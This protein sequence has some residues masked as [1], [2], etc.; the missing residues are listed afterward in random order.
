MS[1][2]T[3]RVRIV[4][5]EEGKVAKI[6]DL[7]PLEHRLV[8][9]LDGQSAGELYCSR[10]SLEALAVGHLAVKGKLAAKGPPG[11]S[12]EEG[13]HSTMA[14]VTTPSEAA[15]P[16]PLEDAA[17]PPGMGEPIS[18]QTII[19]NMDSLAESSEIFG[20]TGAAHCSGY[21]LGD[22]SLLLF[23]DIARHNTIDRIIGSSILRTM[24]LSR[25]MI[26]TTGRV[27][28]EIA[29]RCVQA[30]VTALVSRGA[31]TGRAIEISRVGGLTLVGFAR[32]HRFNCYSHPDR[33]LFAK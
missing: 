31:P 15:T 30:G 16:D 14:R 20:A 5:F 19:D 17:S 1:R 27:S 13:K 7:V 21:F 3:T 8:L 10:G 28:A 9:Y 33:I 18:P 4:R 2:K 11:V 29:D 6:D 24:D 22:Q 32:G 25:G 23:E 26:C 12:L